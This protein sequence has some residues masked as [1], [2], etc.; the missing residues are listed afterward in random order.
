MTVVELIE[1]LQVMPHNAEVHLPND[2]GITGKMV[3][4][5]EQVWNDF[6][7]NYVVVL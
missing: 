4:P 2:E 1:A 7:E 6:A 5:P 3:R